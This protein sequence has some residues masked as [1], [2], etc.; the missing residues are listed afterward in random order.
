MCLKL[1]QL[2]IEDI[3][4]LQGTTSPALVL[5]DP[6]HLLD[7]IPIFEKHGAHKIFMSR[8][9][10]ALFVSSIED[11]KRVEDILKLQSTTYEGEPCLDCEEKFEGTECAKTELPLLT[12]LVERR[13]A[14][15]SMLLVEAMSPMTFH[16]TT[17]DTLLG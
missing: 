4:S 11:K 17:F 7:S 14:R 3:P 6:F 15:S 5:N 8:F 1:T 10:A 16:Y 9:S 2:K 12:K 13:L